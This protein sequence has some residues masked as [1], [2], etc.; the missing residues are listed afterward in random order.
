MII[1]YDL[2]AQAQTNSCNYHVY[3]SAYTRDAESIPIFCMIKYSK[4]YKKNMYIHAY[5]YLWYICMEIFFKR[6]H[7]IFNSMK[8]V[9]SI[10][11]F[12]ICKHFFLNISNYN[13]TEKIFI[14]L[15]FIYVTFEFFTIL[16]WWPL[17]TA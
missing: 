11:F 3:L 4:E 9:H 6:A 10:F 15:C 17:F 1:T 12:V 7:P 8:S 16:E 5:V 2:T 13:F 14:S